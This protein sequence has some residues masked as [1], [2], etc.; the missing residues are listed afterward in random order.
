L[1]LAGALG[2]VIVALGVRT[3]W[4]T[5]P[6]FV[7][8]LRSNG[9]PILGA[10]LVLRHPGLAGPGY[11]RA[12]CAIDG[13]LDIPRDRIR[14]DTEARAVAPGCGIFRGD[15]PRDGRITLPQAFPAKVTIP[16]DFPLPRPPLALRIM[17]APAGED[18][19]WTLALSYAVVPLDC[20][21]RVH[22]S[23]HSR[24]TLIDPTTR[25]ASLLLPRRGRWIL[26]WDVID[27]SATNPLWRLPVRKLR[28]GTSP[29][30]EVEFDETGEAVAVQ[31][32]EEALR[33]IH[34]R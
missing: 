29:G 17:L 22:A 4:P 14:P 13:W 18:R 7:Q 21:L 10:V 2:V 27:C 19:E 25:S 31:I 33:P 15:L 1:I 24:W 8:I 32:Q 23:E 11:S 12:T 16:G 5:G 28:E 3:A 34:F 9:D 30:I 26:Y 6:R 20:G